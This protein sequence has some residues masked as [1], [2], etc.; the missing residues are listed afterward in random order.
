MPFSRPCRGNRKI[1]QLFIR[2]FLTFLQEICGY[3][4]AEL[5]ISASFEKLKEKSRGGIDFPTAAIYNGTSEL[6]LFIIR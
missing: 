5:I 3:L 6:L 2:Q 4:I 1:W